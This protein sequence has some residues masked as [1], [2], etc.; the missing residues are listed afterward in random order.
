MGWVKFSQDSI[1]PN[2]GK[3]FKPKLV[4]SLFINSHL[5]FLPIFWKRLL[6]HCLCMFHQ[7]SLNY[8]RK[9]KGKPSLDSFFAGGGLKGSLGSLCSG[10][11]LIPWEDLIFPKVLLIR[12]YRARCSVPHCRGP[13]PRS[14]HCVGVASSGLVKKTYILPNLVWPFL[15]N[16]TIIRAIAS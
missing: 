8:K 10:S 1:S 4:T 14:P 12:C 6:F 13:S 3:F 11:H 5:H 9:Q 15:T 16:F 2:A 7:L